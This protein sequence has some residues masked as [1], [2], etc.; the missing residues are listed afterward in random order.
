[1]T[2]EKIST[3]SFVCLLFSDF[4]VSNFEG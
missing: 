1:M 2:A 4:C 3:I